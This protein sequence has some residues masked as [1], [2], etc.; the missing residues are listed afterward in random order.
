MRLNFYFRWTYE[1]RVLMPERKSGIGCYIRL[2]AAVFLPFIL[3]GGIKMI[4]NYLRFGNILDFGIQYSLTIN[5]FMGTE[6]HSHFA[7]IGFYNYLFAVPNTSSSF[8]FISSHVETFNPNG[9]YFVATNTAGLFIMDPLC[10]SY[11]YFKKAYAVSRSENKKL[12]SLIISAL[13]VIAPLVI[14]ASVWESGYGIRYKT[15]F[16]WQFLI[17]AFTIIF[18]IYQNCENENIK[19]VMAKVFFVSTVLC[20]ILSFAQSYTYILKA[21]HFNHGA[22]DKYSYA[23]ERAFEFWR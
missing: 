16:A 7:G 17:G 13:C 20:F 5:D 1:R 4:Y 12:Y 14:I 10:F 8:P 18:I 6:F 19:K 9:Y 15:D 11:F 23:F 21:S 22:A 2:L 3:I